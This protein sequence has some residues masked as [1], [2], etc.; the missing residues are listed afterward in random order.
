[1]MKQ[2]KITFMA[3]VLLSSTIIAYPKYSHA[4][5]TT[6]ISEAAGRIAAT[7]GDVLRIGG[8]NLEKGENQATAEQTGE[9]TKETEA[10]IDK[11]NNSIAAQSSSS[12]GDSSSSSGG[13]SSSSSS[14]S[15][16]S[17]GNDSDKKKQ[18]GI[19]AWTSKARGWATDFA[20][21]RLKTGN[22]DKQKIR[23]NALRLA[24]IEAEILE[25]N[26]QLT[27]VE[28]EKTLYYTTVEKAY[29]EKL[30]AYEANKQK[31]L[32]ETQK[33]N[34]LKLAEQKVAEYKSKLKSELEAKL[35]DKLKEVNEQIGK[36]S[37]AYEQ[38]KEAI[39]KA[40]EQQ[41]KALQQ[42]LAI[43]QA[44]YTVLER[45]LEEL[46]LQLEEDKAANLDT[47]AL[48][49]E[50]QE[51]TKQYEELEK[52]L[53]EIPKKQKKAEENAIADADNLL[54]DFEVEKEIW[55]K[56]YADAQA[57]LEVEMQEK[58]ANFTG[59]ILDYDVN[60]SADKRGALEDQMNE[61]SQ[62]IEA[63]K[64]KGEDTSA[65]EQ[66]ML[67]LQEQHASIQEIDVGS[68]LDG[69][70]A[71]DTAS[72]VMGA[73][74]E[75][76][77]S[78]LSGVLA[79]KAS[80]EDKL[81]RRIADIHNQIRTLQQ[82]RAQLKTQLAEQTAKYLLKSLGVNLTDP[83]DSLNQAMKLNFLDK[84]TPESAEAIDEIRRNRLIERRDAILSSYSD[85][86]MLKLR[87]GEDLDVI[88]YFADNTNSMDTV[89]GVI[90]ADTDIKIKT[91]EAL[92]QYAEL[93]VAELRLE[94]AA[95]LA[96]LNT[97]KVKNPDKE[98]TN[99][100]LDDYLF[101]CVQ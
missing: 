48:E 3:L 34:V 17:G 65:M 29:Q 53:T 84:K 41:Q 71:R 9:G 69:R 90:G 44:D 42:E 24:E 37:A 77:A 74:E 99:F 35:G 54:S 13:D 91:I 67:S 62:K 52:K 89:S 86:V 7:V 36:A 72:D 25:L 101:N 85:A 61:L 11:V 28:T 51:K 92:M 95:E 12:G 76:I 27:L 50:I 88:E 5:V 82:L 20:K 100:N 49:A 98:I 73:M 33:L 2:Y 45:E 78:A 80:Y 68:L 81:Q 31:I 26:L 75:E 18:S 40:N 59:S 60:N 66:E 39:H 79:L 96:N 6:D 58:I 15:S 87:I 43:A 56:K 63:A 94:T 21:K 38:A 55:L 23:D 97:Y 64:A 30:A 22:P 8:I 93:L 16:S 1:M 46:E 4:F 19:K 10:Y 57:F 32:Q 14:S 83:K 47:T 70:F